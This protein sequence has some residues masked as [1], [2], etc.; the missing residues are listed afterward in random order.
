MVFVS[1]DETIRQILLDDENLRVLM[2]PVVSG[3]ACKIS[4]KTRNHMW[5][6][7]SSPS[8]IQHN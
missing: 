7:R 1:E 3:T 8:T 5:F 6:V 2:L 4:I